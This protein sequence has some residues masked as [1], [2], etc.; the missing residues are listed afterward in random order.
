MIFP[1]LYFLKEDDQLLV[2]GF[3]KR[4]VVNGPG[5]FISK[6]FEKT[7]RRKGISIEPTKYL[8]I[9]NKLSGELHNEIGPAFYFLKTNEVVSE[10]LEVIPL[11]KNQYIRLLNTLT[12]VIR[13]ER[14]ET[15][16]YLKSTEKI[17]QNVAD[18][19]NIDEHTAVIVRDLASGQLN[20]IIEPQ[21]F[22]PAENQEI[23]RVEKRI[24]LEDHETVVIKDK[25]GKYTFRKGIDSDR[26]FFL[27]PYSELVKFHWSTGLH[28][29]KRGLEITQI[30]MRP[31]FMWYE[32]EARTQ[33]NVEL[34]LGITFFWQIIDVESM[35]KTTDD[36]PGDICSHARS[37]I[38]QSV[39]RVTLES[40]LAEFNMVVH[41]A[42]LGV[43]DIFYK[44]R[45]VKLHSVEVRS[46]SC[47]DVDTQRVLQEI[48]RETTNRLNRLQIQE[49]ENEV[50]IKQMNG[51][52]ES[53]EMKRKL[54][55]IQRQNLQIAAETQGEAEAKRV[56]AFFDGLGD[57]LNSSDAVSIFNTLRKQ[58]MLDKLSEGTAQIYFTPSDVNLSIESKQK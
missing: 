51:E 16:V 25:L 13:V 26:S 21:V 4:K 45:G 10:T 53:E 9:T 33:D 31:K 41:N 48:I 3:T 39:S 5:V 36:I 58:D 12:G 38:I 56:K 35:I 43:E 14:G 46:I 47:K 40:F 32:F 44:D 11:E 6:P 50:K 24:R 27:D 19:I 15:T 18:G 34:I 54:L 22:I 29:D 37:A 17:I 30:D 42:V 23:I 20:L 57:K 52:I 1:W 2:E 8:R 28:K 49:S 7:R 55:E